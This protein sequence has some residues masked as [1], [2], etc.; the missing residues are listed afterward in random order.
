[1]Q[2]AHGYIHLLPAIPTV[3]KKGEVKGMK[4]VG[5]FT[6]DETWTGGKC[7]RVVIVSNAGS[8]LRV[9]C[10]RADKAVKDAFIYVNGTRLTDVKADEVGIVTIPCQKD[11]K[12]IINFVE[13]ETGVSDIKADNANPNKTVGTQVVYDLSGRR[14]SEIP[15]GRV[16]IQ[17]GNKIIK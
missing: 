2:S 4:A 7:T 1:M 9:R 17:N 10:E 8:E 3:W 11:D 6:V 13:E 12:V 5:N 15:T 16:C 14:I